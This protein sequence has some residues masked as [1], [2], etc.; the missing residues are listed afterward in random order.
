MIGGSFLTQITPG[1]DSIAH[2]HSPELHRWLFHLE[3][4]RTGSC[5]NRLCWKNLDSRKTIP[6]DKKMPVWLL[7]PEIPL[8]FFSLRKT[9]GSGT[10]GDG[11]TA[12]WDTPGW[13]KCLPEGRAGYIAITL[14]YQNPHVTSLNS[15]RSLWC[16]PLLLLLLYRLGKIDLLVWD[17]LNGQRVLGAEAEQAEGGGFAQTGESSNS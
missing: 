10:L 17:C 2:T 9:Q 15:P 4:D 1:I 12:S 7:K 13:E 14:G 16:K 11:H 6:T 3:K 5:L 8:N